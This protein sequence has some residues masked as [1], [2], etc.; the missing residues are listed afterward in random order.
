MRVGI[1]SYIWKESLGFFVFLYEKRMK[2][3]IRSFGV[4]V[5]SLVIGFNKCSI[6]QFT[7]SKFESVVGVI[8]V[9]DYL[10]S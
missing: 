10:T 6:L 3:S 1:E 8:I 2:G 9:M 4:F 5:G 7:I